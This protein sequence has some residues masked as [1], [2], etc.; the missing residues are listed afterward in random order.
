MVIGLHARIVDPLFDAMKKKRR[1]PAKI[2]HQAS[3][4]STRRTAHDPA[5]PAHNRSC[6]CEKIIFFDF[7]SFR[8]FLPRIN[9]KG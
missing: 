3:G 9:R 2:A 7:F 6:V 5:G 4:N 1:R 8:P